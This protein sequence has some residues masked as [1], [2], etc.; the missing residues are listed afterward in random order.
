M[1]EC[2]KRPNAGEHSF[3]W[4]TVSRGEWDSSRGSDMD[5]VRILAFLDGEF[6]ES[7]E[8]WLVVIDGRTHAAS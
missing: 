1:H 7:L 4:T 2:T 3:G 8:R 5:A 6:A